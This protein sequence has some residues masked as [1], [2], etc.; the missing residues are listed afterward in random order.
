MTGLRRSE[1]ARSMVSHWNLAACTVHVLGKRGERTVPFSPELLPS[2]NYLIAELGDVGPSNPDSISRRL[3]TWARRIGDDRL[4]PHALRHTYG[5]ALVRQG[6]DVFSVMALMGHRT[7]QQTQRY[8]H[9]AGQQ[10]RE[11][12][13]ALQLL[14]PT[15]LRLVAD[16]GPAEQ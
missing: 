9:A 7:P 4:H 15:G 1:L 16:P 12:A 5:T 6:L 14:P 8:F 2:V 10:L 3:Q 11:A 13:N